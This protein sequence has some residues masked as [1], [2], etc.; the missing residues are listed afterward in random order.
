[1]IV[2]VRFRL[3]LCA[4]AFLLPPLAGCAGGRYYDQGRIAEQRGEPQVAYDQYCKAAA[5]QPGDGQIAAALARVRPAAAAF[6]E[7]RGVAQ[8]DNGNYG[9]AWRCFLKALDVQPDDA[10]AIRMIQ[11]LETE[12]GT[13]VARAK[14]VW[15]RQ[16]EVA[17]AT[18]K[19]VPPTQVASAQRTTPRR[20][21]PPK[22]ASPPEQPEETQVAAAAPANPPPPSATEQPKETSPAPAEPVATPQVAM[23][24]PPRPVDQAPPAVQQPTE[25]AAALPPGQTPEP[26]TSPRQGQPEPA[27]ELSH[28][29]PPPP[30]PEIPPEVEPE[31]SLST[32]PPPPRANVYSI[33]LTLS[34]RDRS[35][36]RRTNL[37][38]DIEVYLKDTD[39]DLEV[40]LDL[41]QGKKRVKKIRDLTPGR[42]QIFRGRS[43]MVYRLT[44]LAVDHDTHTVRIGVRP[45]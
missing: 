28:R 11:Q 41:Y 12:H 33:V 30:E 42:S 8:M 4:A 34:K 16:G 40:E 36:P 21:T 44:L 19:Y 32:A 45:A 10:T 7:A 13:E 43:G 18:A 31:P 23:T 5:N 25:F 17:L 38:D 2:P 3:V 20:R 24:E 35:H 14:A 37:V 6:W 1:M 15:L 22:P 9:E 29:P 39:S 26:P 27:R